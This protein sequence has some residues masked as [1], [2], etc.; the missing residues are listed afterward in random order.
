MQI[1]QSEFQDQLVRG[2]AHRM[3][4]ILTLFHGYVGLLL[5]NQKLDQQTMEGLAKIKE[6]ATAASELM[7]RTHSLARPST[8]VWREVKIADFLRI[9][10][11]GVNDA[12]RALGPVPEIR[13]AFI[14]IQAHLYQ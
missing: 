7:D 5:D 1:Q 13:E 10:Y 9:R 3:N 14:A 11:G 2:I 6:G 4:N 12:Q 8:L